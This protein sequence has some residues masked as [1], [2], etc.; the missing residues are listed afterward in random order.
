MPIKKKMQVCYVLYVTR[1]QDIQVWLEKH[2]SAKWNAHAQNIIRYTSL[3][4]SFTLKK[5]TK[6]YRVTH[7]N[8]K[9]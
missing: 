5:S 6:I 9:K 7:A 3:L 2:A 1:I 4:R 8:I